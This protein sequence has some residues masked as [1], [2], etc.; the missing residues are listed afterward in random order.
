VP[1]ERPRTLRTSHSRGIPHLGVAQLAES[2]REMRPSLD[3]G[4]A[5]AVHRRFNRPWS[6]S[7]VFQ[8]RA[9]TS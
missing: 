4:Y 3:A 2:P 6:V 9:M 1:D 5:F 7:P 8:S